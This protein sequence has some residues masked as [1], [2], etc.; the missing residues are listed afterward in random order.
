[1]AILR[2]FLFAGVLL[3]AIPAL[4]D[5]P[6]TQLPSGGPESLPSLGPG[7]P[8]IM[9]SGEAISVTCYLGNP[10]N[11]QSLGSIIVHSPEAAGPTCNSFNHACQGRCY[12]CYSDFD[13]S[14]DICV[15]N[16]GRKFLR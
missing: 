6:L 5:E 2:L 11:R 13:L 9:T 10:N 16:V 3:A 15:D 7:S 12:G 8:N 4:G 1:M 14:E